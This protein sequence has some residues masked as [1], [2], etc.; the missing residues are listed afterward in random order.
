M[1]AAWNADKEI[2][3]LL[4]AAIARDRRAANDLI[5]LIYPRVVVFC[6]SKLSSHG[7]PTPE[8][9]AQDVCIAVAKA[10]PRYQDA[11]APFMAFV[12]QVARNK[13]TDAYR[14][15]QRDMSDPAEELPEEE[16][17]QDS[18][19]EVYL[20]HDSCNDLVKK[21]DILSEKSKEIL[22]LR[23]VHGYTA[24]ETAEIVGSKP[25]AVRV[26]QHRAVAKLKKH[27]IIQSR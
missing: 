7:Y 25:T 18:P 16:S 24:E 10:L 23:V 15:R 2:Q 27:G 13:I 3:D 5:K 6:R 1:A 11:G 19:E 26:A 8:D 20:S 12:Y 9:V 17:F 21:L 22:L 4:P 14:S